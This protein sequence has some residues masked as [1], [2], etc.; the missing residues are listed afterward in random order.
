MS[1]PIK[2]STGS[3]S[4][5][6]KKGNFY[7]G[8]G[9][10]EKGPTNSTGYYNGINPPSGGYT[11][12]LNKESNGP[13]I[14]VANSDSQL[15]SLT[16]VIANASY[17]TVSECLNYYST[18]SD[19][20]CTNREYEAISTEGLILNMDPGYVASYPRTGNT[21]YDTS[22]EDNN[23]TLIN[24]PIFSFSDNE[25]VILFDGA[26]DYMDLGSNINLSG[27][28]SFVIWVKPS[29]AWVSYS[30]IIENAEN[31]NNLN[32]RIQRAATNNSF[33]FYD[34]NF[35]SGGPSV[36]YNNYQ[37]IVVTCPYN[38]NG[39]PGTTGSIIFYKNGVKH[40]LVGD[41]SYPLDKFTTTEK[42]IIGKVI[43]GGAQYR[44]YVAMV[45]IYD[46][47]LSDSE[48]LALYNSQSS[49]FL[50]STPTPTPTVTVTPTVTPG[51][52]PTPTPTSIAIPISSLEVWLDANSGASYPGSG[53]VWYDISGNNN[54]ATL[55]NGPTF[56]DGAILFDGSNDYATY[57]Y[58]AS[59]AMTI[60]TVG[61][62]RQSNW[63]NFASLGSSRAN[64]GFIIHNDAG[65]LNTRYFISTST[66]G[67]TFVD[68]VYPASVNVMRMYSVSTNGT[69]SHKRYL[70]GSL[71][72]TNTT[73][74]TRGTSNNTGYLAWDSPFSRYGFVGIRAHIIYNR[75]L[76]DA[77]IT[78]IYNY[79]FP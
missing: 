31:A 64:N 69:N 20:Y 49:R 25:G 42:T 6:L 63:N 34:N 74:I 53:T 38:G 59:A 78:Q 5:A 11:I 1:N 12:Y 73:G 3:E 75:Q 52:S 39:Q 15:I 28:C 58:G 60:I 76:S 19:K 17:T 26:D 10:V 62:S 16:N 72:G 56:S 14:F 21:C 4:L 7:I 71:V 46:R 41:F 61:Y 51:L 18:Q 2:Y 68:Y 47:L 70:D 48:V 23:A 30:V 13:S 43:S 32:W 9:D 79:Y 67:N 65:S 40:G 35:V 37:Q 54:N 66:G 36:D 45:Q 33:Q 77:E 27:N 24:N 22:I 55:V 8:T 57:P 44:G 50:V 29:A